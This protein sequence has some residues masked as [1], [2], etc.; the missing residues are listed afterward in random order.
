LLALDLA[1][2]WTLWP[3]YRSGWG[4]RLWPK[5]AWWLV[6]PGIG[7]AVALA[8][9]AMV[10]TFPDERIYVAT[11][12][13]HGS[14]YFDPDTG[15]VS[16]RDRPNWYASIAPVNTLAL[17]GE[18]LI[19]DAK[20]AHILEK[21]ENSTG[22]QRWVATLP[23]AGRDL[24]GADLSSADVRHADFSQAILNRADLNYAWAEKAHF[25]AAQ[26]QGAVLVGAQL[27]GPRSSAR[28]SRAPCS[29]ARS[30]RAPRSSAR[31]SRAPRSSARSSRAPRSKTRSSRAPRL[32][33]WTASPQRHHSAKAWSPE[34]HKEG[35]HP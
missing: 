16:S 19:D 10:A 7:S 8:Y 24:T 27:Q 35:D 22:A 32:M 20:L 15:E 18:D 9:A 25:A 3:G 28:S 11:H 17:R 1:L 12:W 14:T 4:V 21:N 34:R 2:V 6:V 5:A 31:S 30:S 26:L 33:V 29:S 23:L 13:L